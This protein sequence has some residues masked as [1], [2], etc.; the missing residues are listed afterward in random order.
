M[1]K[2]L[3]SITYL[4]CTHPIKTNEAIRE[5]MEYLI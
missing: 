1:N 4:N 2:A 5:F 3:T